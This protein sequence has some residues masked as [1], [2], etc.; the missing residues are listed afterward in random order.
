MEVKETLQKALEQSALQS[1]TRGMCEAYDYCKFCKEPTS[2]IRRSDTP[3]ADAYVSMQNI[4][5]MLKRYLT[6]KAKISTI[7]ERIK[8]WKNAL[9]S[10]EIVILDVPETTLGMPRAKYRI[11]SPVEKEVEYKELDRKKIKEMIREEQSKLFIL[12]TE[13][14]KLDIAFS[15][16]PQK[17]MFLIEC[18]YFE[19]MNWRD[20]EEA[21]N[22]KYNKKV[23]EKRL[24]NKMTSIKKLILDIIMQ[25]GTKVGQKG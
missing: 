13:V 8:I 3:C 24:R 25:S 5:K 18:K 4:N 21:Y 12:E 14:N 15:V 16:L 19:N 9:E 10:D 23:T 7:K 1:G 6:N 11:T 20:I 2:F 22:K 17:D